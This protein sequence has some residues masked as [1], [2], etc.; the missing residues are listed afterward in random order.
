ME[1]IFTDLVVIGDSNI[2]IL[3]Y[4]DSY[5]VEGGSGF[6][7]LEGTSVG[8]TAVNTAICASRLGLKV[9]I[10]TG[11]GKDEPGYKI[12]EI[13]EKENIITQYIKRTDQPTGNVFTIV[14][15]TSGERTFIALRE[16]CADWQL[17]RE[18]LSRE[19]IHST[20]AIFISGVG[21]TE[22]KKI[23]PSLELI[24][25]AI[26]YAE[27]R[28]IPIFFDPNLRIPDK[29]LPQEVI[30]VL[31]DIISHSTYYLPNEIE[32]NIIF[33]EKVFEKMPVT[34]IKRGDKGVVGIVDDKKYEIPAFKVKVVDTSGAGD[35]FNAG[36]IAAFLHPE[37]FDFAGKDI[38]AVNNDREYEI[39]KALIAGSAVAGYVV[40][41]RGTLEAFPFSIEDLKR[42]LENQKEG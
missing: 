25:A 20:R 39:F 9:A 17:R 38:P 42:F 32:H 6:G 35:S 28:K 12:F 41:K 34:I 15:K 10:V 31:K 36:F 13:L 33:K 5:P 27:E 40:S 22:N 23:K 4:C 21:V 19:L 14:N 18:D 7:K 26:E 1:K 29:S 11:L 3:A 16:Q 8:G 2:D 37:C 24:S 30:T